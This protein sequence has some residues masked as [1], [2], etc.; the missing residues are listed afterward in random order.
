MARATAGTRGRVRSGPAGLAVS[1]ETATVLVQ[2]VAPVTIQRPEWE[3]SHRVS[4]LTVIIS[5]IAPRRA[6]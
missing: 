4:I 3:R 5:A 2:R 1:R 6:R